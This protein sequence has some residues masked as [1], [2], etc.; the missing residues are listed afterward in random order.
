MPRRMDSLRLGAGASVVLRIPCASEEGS[1]SEFFWT[2]PRAA[3]L[4]P[5]ACLAMA[6]FPFRQCPAQDLEPE[7]D[8]ELEAEMEEETDFQ[9][10][11]DSVYLE[12]EEFE[13]VSAE[14]KPGEKAGW[15]AEADSYV[16]REV[17][18]P[19]PE[20]GKIQRRFEVP[21]AGDYA[22]WVR[23]FLKPELADPFELVVRQGDQER[24]RGKFY[25]R[26]VERGVTAADLE[27]GR[28]LWIDDPAVREG[29]FTSETFVW[30][31]REVKLGPGEASVELEHHPRPYR[32]PTRFRVD[33]LLLT[34]SKSYRPAFRDFRTLFVRVKVLEIEPAD[35]EFTCAFTLLRHDGHYT[36]RD[37][38]PRWWYG[39]VWGVTGPKK[40][41]L[42]AGEY[43]D[44]VNMDVHLKEGALPCTTA[45]ELKGKSLGR[46]RVQLEAAWGMQ[47]SQ[48]VKRVVE[49]GM[50][51]LAGFVLPCQDV[52]SRDEVV[53]SVWPQRYRDTVRG[54]SEEAL[55]RLELVRSFERSA[56][57]RPEKVWV[58]IG[59][60]GFGG[61][62]SSPAVSE[63]EAEVLERIGA[64]AGGTGVPEIDG[65]HGIGPAGFGGA[66]DPPTYY[67][68][69]VCPSGPAYAR[70]IRAH[71]EREAAAIRKSRP[72]AIES[73]RRFK[74]GD[75][76]GYAT[77]VAHA[78]Q[79]YHCIRAFHRFLAENGYRP[80]DFG[81]K[82]WNPSLLPLEKD[83]AEGRIGRLL[84][85]NTMRFLATL[86]GRT[87][88]QATRAVEEHFS[89]D[90]RTYANF[91][92]HPITLGSGM[93]MDWFELSRQRGVTLGWVEGWITMGSWGGPGLQI[94][95]YLTEIIRSAH[96]KQPP[97]PLG[98]YLVG[99]TGGIRTQ[100]NT[101]LAHGGKMVDVYGYGPQY[102]ATE[103]YFAEDP[104]S[105]RGCADGMTSL[106]KADALIH[107]GSDRPAD[108]ALLYSRSAELWQEDTAIN[109]NRRL[110]YLALLHQHLRVDILTED[111]L[112]GGV[113]EKYRA[114]Y[115][116]GLNVRRDGQK[117][118]R[119]W[120]GRG[121]VV[122]AD[123]GCAIRDESDSRCR[124]LDEVFGAS[125]VRLVQVK[126][127][128]HE[129]QFPKLKDLDAATYEA[130]EH[131]PAGPARVVGYRETLKAEGGEVLAT[132]QDGSPAAL[133]HGFGKGKAFRFAYFPAFTYR[134]YATPEALS[135]PNG[136]REEERRIIARA[137]VTAGCRGPVALSDPLVE[138]G[139]L[140]SA[141]GRALILVNFRFKEIPKLDVRVRSVP[142]VGL[143]ES[144]Y[145]GPLD[146]RQEGA[147]VLFSMPL[148][149]SDVV[150][151]R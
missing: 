13:G 5:W 136:Y 103:T 129:F 51:P 147:D 9:F 38:S 116:T 82:S 126:T 105:L 76:I 118:I 33:G 45:V 64:N 88:A 122:W 110:I 101:F 25:D 59:A 12:A 145:Q 143:V 138:P 131:F 14:T 6:V 32:Q 16:C 20:G 115:L 24:F 117:V 134:L 68:G 29:I 37:G 140:E 125:H 43:S 61:Y 93:G 92:P 112:V 133:V 54:I 78:R 30:D 83:A 65:R 146:F 52:R 113:L 111:D 142:G 72:G 75:E 121:G 34:R 49:E 62:H 71:Y 123:A 124:D 135:L 137:A 2:R 114:L 107:A 70:G 58:S 151:L 98:Y 127:S 149:T 50:L 3:L 46:C 41:P 1:P 19:L 28:G 139:L 22:L 73:Y 130:S 15:K 104:G 11:A 67:S 42:K 128:Y 53:R 119:D 21:A 87:Y 4:I 47:D 96:R 150:I 100:F 144:V 102:A 60:G 132:F 91:S 84:Y 108:T 77:T 31:R 27:K 10:L 48:V 55:K 69:T 95:S 7:E 23:Y 40:A 8:T 106:G 17:A 57:A 56:R 94:L 35:A 44:W 86:T 26:P 79:C 90:V 89:P 141:G 85:F 120:V 66:A 74:L 80:E 36:F 97:G 39:G 63:A 148:G 81:E 109:T 99:S 18:E